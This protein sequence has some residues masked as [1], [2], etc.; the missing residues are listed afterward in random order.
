MYQD[1]RRRPL[2][3]VTGSR[4]ARHRDRRTACPPSTS[5]PWRVSRRSCCRTP[6]RSITVIDPD[7]N[8][9]HVVEAADRLHRRALVGAEG[10]SRAADRQHLAR[11]AVRAADRH[12][13]VRRPARRYDGR[14]RR[15]RAAPASSGTAPRWRSRRHRRTRCTTPRAMACTSWSSWSRTSRVRST[16]T[17]WRGSAD[18]RDRRPQA[19]RQP[20]S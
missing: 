17:R 8:P 3:L 19:V 6:N 7:G 11:T 2:V 1:A 4:P 14:S 20:G 18:H 16:E 12:R 13:R 9:N 5:I 15:L 10:H